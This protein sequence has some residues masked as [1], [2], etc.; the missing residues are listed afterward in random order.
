MNKALDLS[1]ALHD[2]DGLMH[3]CVP[4]QEVEAD[5]SVAE[6]SQQQSST[7]GNGRQSFPCWRS[8]KKRARAW[9]HILSTLAQADLS[10]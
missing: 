7:Q 8:N 1:S 10:S 9:W 3:F 5:P 4:N 2:L 6:E